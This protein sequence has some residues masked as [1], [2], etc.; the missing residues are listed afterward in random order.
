MP[1]QTSL[2]PP[3]WLPLAE[4]AIAR[5][6]RHEPL[7]GTDKDNDKDANEDGSDRPPYQL[8]P[9]GRLLTEMLVTSGAI[10]R[11]HPDD[12]AALRKS[13]ADPEAVDLASG[14]HRPAVWVHPHRLLLAIRIAALIGSQADLA[15]WLA[16]GA[17]TILAG[18]DD[19]GTLKKLLRQA[20]L[21]ETWRASRYQDDGDPTKPT[22]FVAAPEVQGTGHVTTPAEARFTAAIGRV[23]EEAGPV[24]ITLP[25]GYRIPN[26]V[27]VLLPPVQDLPDLDTDILITLLRHTHSATGRIDEARVRAALPDD[28]ALST[29]TPGALQIALRAETAHTVAERIAQLLR[30]SAPTAPRSGPD[31]DAMTGTSQALTTA[32]RMVSDLQGW[33]RG[34]VA[35]SEL[36]RSLLLYGPPGTGKTWLA[37]AMANAA[38]ISCVQASYGEWQAAGHLGDLLR[39]MRRSFE[40]ARETAPC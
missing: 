21:P 20:F 22:L 36:S 4:S 17:V 25:S 18:I 3:I 35:W 32:R 2:P 9:R 13:G 11:H 14:A 24:L 19:A 23:L 27:A 16:P 28:A 10:D 29:L 37:Q 7:R 1:E 6:R 34:E 8:T 5:L 39:E 15:R 40:H 33:Q 12:R 30:N 31:L 38:G 26:K